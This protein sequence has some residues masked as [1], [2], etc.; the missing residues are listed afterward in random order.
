MATVQAEQHLAV[1]IAE[2][3]WI[4]PGAGAI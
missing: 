3:A 2:I 4:G 1:E